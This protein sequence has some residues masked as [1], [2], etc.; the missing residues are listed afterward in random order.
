MIGQFGDAEVFSFNATKA[1]HTGEAGAITCNDDALAEKLKAIRNF[2]FTDFDHTEYA[3]TNGKMP[4]T[5]AALGLTN[6]E[7]FDRNKEKAREIHLTYLQ[8]F[9]ETEMLQQFQFDENEQN[10]YHYVSL[11]LD[12]RCPLSAN[13]LI[14]ILHA[15]NIL[16]R[17]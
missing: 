6:I 2:G 16:A 4:E 15:E 3:G 8:E 13:D 17:R 7:A 5:S 1:Y 14:A 12:A 11:L 10:N 9:T